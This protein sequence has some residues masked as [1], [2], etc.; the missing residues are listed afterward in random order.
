M[1]F[2]T[3]HIIS[4]ELCYTET[5]QYES[6]YILLNH[7][8][9][10]EKELNQQANHILRLYCTVLYPWFIYKN[11]FFLSPIPDHFSGRCAPPRLLAPFGLQ[12][13]ECF[14]L[15]KRVEIPTKQPLQHNL[16]CQK[17]VSKAHLARCMG[18][19]GILHLNKKVELWL[20]KKHCLLQFM[21]QTSNPSG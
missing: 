15:A 20:N 3:I 5:N 19:F 13:L 10:E 12:F 9:G 7:H 6:Y 4:H 11:R 14:G 8:F 1:L 17:Y 16:G 2:N 21:L 18:W